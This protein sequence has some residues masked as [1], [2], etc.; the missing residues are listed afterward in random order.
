MSFES[1][2]GRTAARSTS[3]P[4]RAPSQG[5]AQQILSSR[6]AARSTLCPFRAPLRRA[7]SKSYPQGRRRAANLILKDDGAQ[8]ILSGTAVRRT[9]WDA[10]GRQL[11]ADTTTPAGARQ[12]LR[13]NRQQTPAEGPS[14]R[15]LPSPQ[16]GPTPPRRRWR[17]GGLLV[18]CGAPGE[19]AASLGNAA[20]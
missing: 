3:C 11:A 14:H 7:R 18:R 5:G 8:H 2:F 9:P 1:A 4:L 16:L 12:H 10:H 13:K 20:T 6:T 15:T 17:L 19:G